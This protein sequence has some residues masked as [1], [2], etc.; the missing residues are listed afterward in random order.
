M[1]QRLW[2]RL[3]TG[4]VPE[5]CIK[6]LVETS[7]ERSFPKSFS[8]MTRSSRAYLVCAM[9][10]IDPVTFHKLYEE[11]FL[12]AGNLAVERHVESQKQLRAL[13]TSCR[14]QDLKVV[15]LLAR[16]EWN[17][18][19][20]ISD[21]MYYNWIHWLWRTTEDPEEA[22]HDGANLVYGVEKT[23]FQVPTPSLRWIR[24]Q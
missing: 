3:L 1:K 20:T 5:K 7:H 14:E 22:Y 2:L 8:S 23:D 13:P 15:C 11:V 18:Y 9:H 4:K 21:G 16:E 19:P 12:R 24:C 6:Q 17:S 10:K